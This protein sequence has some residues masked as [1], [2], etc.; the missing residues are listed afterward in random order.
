[1]GPMEPNLVHKKIYC[2][3]TK[4]VECANHYCNLVISGDIV[5]P[6]SNLVQDTSIDLESNGSALVLD[7]DTTMGLIQGGTTVPDSNLA[8]DMTIKLGYD[9]FGVGINADSTRI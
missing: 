3:S 5:I 7:T 9:E 4:S 8:Q 1:V 2:E 6:D